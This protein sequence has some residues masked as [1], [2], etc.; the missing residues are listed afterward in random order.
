LEKAV[1]SLPAGFQGLIALVKTLRGEH[2]CPWDREQTPEQIKTYLLEEAYEVLEALDSGSHSDVCGELGDL[3]F[4]IVFLARI[5][6][7][8]GDFN[9]DDVV[10]AIN[11]KMI[12][13]HPHVFGEVQVSSSDE[14][15]QRWHDI[16]VAEVKDKNTLQS[17]SLDSVPSNLPALMRAYRVTERAT[18][19][20][21]EW[22][23]IDRV[24]KRLDETLAELKISTKEQNAERLAEGL[25]DLL[26]AIVHLAQSLQVHPETAL[27]RTVTDF[28]RRFEAVEKV[29]TE[30]G[31]TFRSVSAREVDTILK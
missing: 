5:F 3:L 6:E 1:V 25:G 8:V 17:A 29:L 23:D 12:R 15:R 16:K 9:I 13:R 19:L 26:F 22:P 2:G 4:H 24:L 27:T 7:E 11:T 28:I 31:R 20:G 18:K 30:Q 10:E 21:F 14:V